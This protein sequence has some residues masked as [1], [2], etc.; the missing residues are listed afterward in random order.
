MGIQENKTILTES[1]YLFFLFFIYLYR[2]IHLIKGEK[3]TNRGISTKHAFQE[4]INQNEVPFWNSNVNF[5]ICLLSRIAS[6]FIFFCVWISSGFSIHI[7]DRN[8]RAWLLKIPDRKTRASLNTL[9]AYCRSRST[10]SSSR[11]SDSERSKAFKTQL[12]IITWRECWW[13]L[14]FRIKW[15]AAVSWHSSKSFAGK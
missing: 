6:L 15:T 5:L 4:G 14:R 2:G 13:K 11:S 10:V 7:P 3:I 1:S 12:L 8:S 9:S